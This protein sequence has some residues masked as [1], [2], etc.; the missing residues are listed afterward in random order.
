MGQE[1][2]TARIRR[3]DLSS[4]G[5]RASAAPASPEDVLFRAYGEVQPGQSGV[6]RVTDRREERCACGGMLVDNGTEPIRV[7]VENH[8][9]TALHRAWRAW[10]ETA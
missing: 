2:P 9:E 8:N 7:I 6:F 5:P 3:L 10:R 1:R 4:A